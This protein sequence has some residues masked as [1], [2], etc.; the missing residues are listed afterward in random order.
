[1]PAGLSER[2]AYARDLAPGTVLAQEYLPAQP[3][4]LSG[5][6]SVAI[7]ATIGG[8]ANR[9]TSGIVDNFDDGVMTPAVWGSSHGTRG[10]TGGR[11]FVEC[12][13]GFPAFKT[14][15]VYKFDSFTVQPFPAARN[16]ATT[17]ASSGILIQSPSVA[18]GTDIGFQW[19]MVAGTIKFASRTGYFDGGA[20][21]LAY[22]PV[23]H[24]YVRMRLV[25]GNVL[26]DT[27][28]DNATW[29]NRRTLTAPAWLTTVTDARLI[30]EAHRSDGT[31]NNFE[32]DNLNTTAGASYT[33]D[34]T[35]PITA[36]IGTS[37][38]RSAP[39]SSSVAIT[40]TTST[41]ATGARTADA[42]VPVTATIATTAARTAPAVASVPVT[43]SITSDAT[44]AAS[45]DVSV[46]ITAT[47][48][49]SAA[50][51][52]IAAVPITVS[53]ATTPA[54]T[55][56]ADASVSVVVSFTTT[57]GRTASASASVPITVTAVTA[58]ALSALLTAAVAI[59]AT[60]V[61]IAD[62]AVDVV[63]FLVADSVLTYA[64]ADSSASGVVQQPDSVL[65]A[66]HLVE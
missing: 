34:A 16:A 29:T 25:G 10:E 66:V 60:I 52:A 54:V 13:T 47:I 51:G 36:T 56:P 8:S 27:S 9:M 23:A 15:D 63:D 22:D 62:Q 58:G 12:G 46:P 48:S 32:F 30:F 21:N 1:M 24:A 18:G 33:G 3:A 49:T 41:T 39:A 40:A 20:G 37:A 35:V 65:S 53:V 5:A 14:Y 11:G 59:T 19:D 45:G 55:R 4:V 44:R 26:W 64:S 28:P 61:A 7:T 43:V 31:V 38:S 2:R 50:S 6:A 57:A 17:E 42:A